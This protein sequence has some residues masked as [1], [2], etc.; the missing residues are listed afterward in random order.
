MILFNSLGKPSAQ[1]NETKCTIN[2]SC[3][4]Y[5]CVTL[6]L[7]IR[8]RLCAQWP[9]SGCVYLYFVVQGLPLEV[10]DWRQ[11]KGKKDGNH[12]CFLKLH[13]RN[14]P[15]I[16]M[17]MRQPSLYCVGCCHD[18]FSRALP[19]A[20]LA[21]HGAG[22]VLPAC[23][24]SSNSASKANTHCLITFLSTGKDNKTVGKMTKFSAPFSVLGARH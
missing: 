3:S 4:G 14:L 12:P 21:N 11:E 22:A 10:K 15:V 1:H 20:S 17:R 7:E 8:L 6:T 9:Y 5:H 19:S 16:P 18:F 2:K 13:L 24:V 23:P